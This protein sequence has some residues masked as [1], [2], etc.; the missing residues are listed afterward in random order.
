MRTGKRNLAAIVVIVSSV[1]PTLITAQQSDECR[2]KR[3]QAAWVSSPVYNDANELSLKLTQSGF[4]VECI[5]RS[6]QEHLFE[7]QKGAAWFST[8]RGTFEVW[9]LPEDET[10]ASLEVIE[11]PQPNGRYIYAFRGKPQIPT[12]MDSAKRIYFI[13]RGSVMFEVSGDSQLAASL[14]RVLPSW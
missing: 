8:N 2:N 14:E 11:Q 5:R 13:K 7:G 4:L 12:S 10:F 3:G 1:W 9:F 6:K